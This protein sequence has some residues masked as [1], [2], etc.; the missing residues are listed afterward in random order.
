MTSDKSSDKILEKLVIKSEIKPH[1]HSVYTMTIE[2]FDADL[3]GA[4]SVNSDSFIESIGCMPYL[5]R[6]IDSKLLYELGIYFATETLNTQ[7]NFW[8]YLMLECNN[9]TYN[10]FV[11]MHSEK[12]KERVSPTC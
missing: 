2:D 1:E 3:R 8:A 9:E 4:S 10:R 11:Q 12:I 6:T 5:P 7:R